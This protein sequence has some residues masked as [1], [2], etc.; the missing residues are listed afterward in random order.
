M[1][2]CLGVVMGAS[3][4]VVILNWNGWMDTVECLESVYRMSYDPM[5]V[6]VVDNGSTDESTL[7]FAE[8][9]EGKLD[10]P[11][12]MLGSGEASRP[13]QL[14]KYTREEAEAVQDGLGVPGGQ[15]ASKTMFMIVNDRNYGFAKGCNVGMSFA[16]KTVRPDYILL[17][18]NDTVVGPDL[19]TEL[20]KVGESDERIGILGPKILHYDINGRKDVIW[21]AGGGVNP[22]RE[23]VISHVGSGEID[24]GQY[25]SIAD[26]EWCTGAAML[27][28]TALAR[29]SLLNPAYLFGTE[30]AEYCM[31]ARRL[32]YRIVYV[33]TAEVWHK[34]GVSWRKLGRRIGRDIPSYFYFIKRN[35]SSP[36]YA[37]HIFLFF[38]LVLPRWAVTYLVDRRDGKA[39]RTFMKEM[40][41]FVESIVS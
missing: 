16:L 32:G 33:P 14:V 22:W 23:L 5:F 3:V 30:D 24:K 20:V 19:L 1:G 28:K 40:K 13:T 11:S 41:Q 4:A 7:R 36:V 27:V 12:R 10:V 31:N 38:T 9:C 34:V 15:K 17:L 8:F 37:Y 6:I 18:N 2:I 21:Y 35:F 25:D 29:S 26:T 39:L